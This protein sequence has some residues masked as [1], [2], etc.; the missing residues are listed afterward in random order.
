MGLCH[1]LLC[2]I[3]KTVFSQGP[4]S[5][6]AN[7]QSRL[8]IR[9]LKCQR[10]KKVME[11]LTCYEVKRHKQ[12]LLQ[13]RVIIQSSCIVTSSVTEKS[14]MVYEQCQNPQD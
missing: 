3:G 4:A 6:Y 1:H 13:P 14:Q 9:T 11:M 10:R 8:T 7:H 12:V 2:F 5:L